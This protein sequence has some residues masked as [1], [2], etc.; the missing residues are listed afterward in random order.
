MALL[1]FSVLLYQSICL[2]QQADSAHAVGIKVHGGITLPLNDLSNILSSGYCGNID[3]YRLPTENGF[4]AVGNVT[5]Q[6]LG[7]KNSDYSVQYYSVTLGPQYLIHLDNSFWS[8]LYFGGSIGVSIIEQKNPP[9][10]NGLGTAMGAN[11]GIKSFEVVDVGI[12]YLYTDQ[13]Y[14]FNTNSGAL[15]INIP[16][17][18]FQVLVGIY[19]F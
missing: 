7:I 12:R 3:F 4:G 15:I 8:S 19:L 10:K 9:Q 14:K 18:F 6:N 2:G 1:C 16:S 11:A 17:R 5:F 13:E